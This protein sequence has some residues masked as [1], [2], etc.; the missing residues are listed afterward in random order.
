MLFPRWS[1][2]D[3]LHP[4]GF[5]ESEEE[6]TRP[7]QE[8]RTLPHLSFGRVLCA[9]TEEPALRGDVMSNHNAPARQADNALLNEIADSVNLR[10]GAVGVANFI[11]VVTLHEGAALK[12]VAREV[13]L[14][15]PVATAVRRELEAIGYLARKGGLVLTK[16]GQAFATSILDIEAAADDTGSNQCDVGNELPEDLV[17]NLR[18]LLEKAPGV[19]VELDQ[20]PCTPETALRRAALMHQAGALEGRQIL[21]LGD[22]DSLSLA[23]P[24]YLAHQG[25]TRPVD[26]I[27]VLEIDPGRISF[28]KE[29]CAEIGTQATMVP[30]DLRDPLPADLRGQFDVFQTDPPY[31]VEGATLF[32]A[33]AAEALRRGPGSLGFLSFGQP[34]TV[35]QYAMLR[36]MHGLGFAIKTIRRDFNT[37]E[38]A[39]I[40]GSTGQMFELEGL[41]GD[42]PSKPERYSGIMYTAEK[43]TR[44]HSYR[45]NQ[46]KAKVILRENGAPRTIEALKEVGCSSCGGT[47][48]SRWR[49]RPPKRRRRG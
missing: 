41:F 13:G 43:T 14:P 28:L 23:I 18:A 39:S 46:C 10:E 12:V 47:A 49:S 17:E 8:Q 48:F 6:A 2:P 22:D 32:L 16:R 30:H 3:Q 38:G 45:C 20:A 5:P 35:D 4:S 31:T 26:N 9:R 29:K 44:R 34:A 33:R 42:A 19:R 25:R 1:C 37:Y 7:L 27:T 24:L 36:E 11:R 15:I 40:L 21:L